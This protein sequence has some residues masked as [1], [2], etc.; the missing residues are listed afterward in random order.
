MAM[1]SRLSGFIAELHSRRVFREAAF[2]GG[3]AL[4]LLQI[5]FNAE[6][7]KSHHKSR[8]TGYGADTGFHF[9]TGTRYI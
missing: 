5:F 4:V 9:S 1:Q 2:Y 7:G 8:F 3:I 6:V